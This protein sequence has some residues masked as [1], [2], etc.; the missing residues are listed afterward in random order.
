MLRL[1]VD[2]TSF[3]LAAHATIPG[4]IHHSSF[5]HLSNGYTC[6][7]LTFTC[8]PHALRLRIWTFA[9]DRIDLR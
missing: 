9:P 6:R 8:T 4:I 1:P 3:E 2:E 5:L 7:I